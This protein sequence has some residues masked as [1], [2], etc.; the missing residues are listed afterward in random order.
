MYSEKKEGTKKEEERKT[1]WKKDTNLGQKAFLCKLIIAISMIFCHY[2][3]VCPEYIPFSPVNSLVIRSFTEF[4]VSQ[5][6]TLSK[7][8]NNTKPINQITKR[9][10]MIPH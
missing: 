1:T 10:A 5:K 2:A 3:F 6:D 8:T 4:P 7:N 9:E